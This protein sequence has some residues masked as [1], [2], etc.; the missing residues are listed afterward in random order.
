MSAFY[1]KNKFNNT[2]VECDCEIG[3]HPSKGEKA[4]CKILDLRVLA[5]EIK[6][7]KRQATVQLTQKV[8]WKVDFRFEFVATGVTAWAE[9]KGKW[10]RDAAMKRNLWEEGFGP[11]PLEIWEGHYRNPSLVRTIIPNKGAA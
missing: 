4:V 7:V 5:R 8:R 6:N 1:R 2:K 11:G 9:Y 10:T 3:T